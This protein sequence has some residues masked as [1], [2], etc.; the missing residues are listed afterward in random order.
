[1][2]AKGVKRATAPTRTCREW[3]VQTETME[4]EEEEEDPEEV[5]RVLELGRVGYSGEGSACEGASLGL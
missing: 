4:E 2:V 5:G 3:E 1:M